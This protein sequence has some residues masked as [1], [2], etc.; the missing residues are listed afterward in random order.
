MKYY[1][2]Y[3]GENGEPQCGS[4]SVFILDG[5]NRLE[6]MI[7]DAHERM[8]RLRFVKPWYASFR[9]MQGSRFSD[10]NRVVYDSAKTW[11]GSRMVGIE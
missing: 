11:N 6:T 4:D 10:S 1:A 3:F 7:D 2:E 9:I 5:R 8:H